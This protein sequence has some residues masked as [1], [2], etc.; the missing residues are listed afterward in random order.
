M[1]KTNKLDKWINRIHH[2]RCEDLIRD[3]PDESIDLVITSPP[4]N[5]DLGNNK[6]N[7]NPY[8]LYNDNKEHQEYILWLCDI[9]GMIKPK[10]VY[11]GR[12]CINVGDGKNG[13]VPTHSD[14]T[15]FMTRDLKYIIKTTILWDKHQIGNRT[16]WGSWMSPKNPSF[17]TP[18]EYIMVFCNEDQSKDGDK[19]GVTLTREQFVTNSLAIW[20]FAPENQMNKKYGHPAMFP[21]ELPYRLIQQLSYKGDVVLDPFS[22]MGTTC[23]AA[24]MLDRSWIGFEMSEEYVEKSKRRINRYVDQSRIF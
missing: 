2:G 22:G 12:V 3:L 14:I 24:A 9:F 18:F 11:G 16:S 4:Y 5:V 23:L 20:E 1:S 6:Y 10:M 17:P 15:Q 8:D 7:K 19:E 21:L 13:A